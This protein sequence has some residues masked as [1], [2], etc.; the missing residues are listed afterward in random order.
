MVLWFLFY[1]IT[2]IYFLYSALSLH[3]VTSAMLHAWTI[4]SELHLFCDRLKVTI[5]TWCAQVQWLPRCRG[6][7]ELCPHLPA[8][9]GLLQEPI[10]AYEGQHMSDTMSPHCHQLWTLS[11]PSPALLQY[12]PWLRTGKKPSCCDSTHVCAHNMFKELINHV[13][14]TQVNI[15]FLLNISCHSFPSCY[16][17]N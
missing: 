12:N 11:S 6:R 17:K 13:I 1:L 7:P 14:W 4:L 5:P 10:T 16:M 3:F 9:R 2:K 8:H 15:N